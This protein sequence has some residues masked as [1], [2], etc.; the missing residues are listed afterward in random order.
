MEKINDNNYEL[1]LVRY[2]DDELTAGEREVVEEWLGE[3][4][5]AAEELALY[6]EAP[7]L[8]ADTTVRYDIAQ[9]RHSKPLWPVVLHWSAAA[10][11]VIAL[12]MPIALMTD[13]KPEGPSVQVAEA[14]LPEAEVVADTVTETVAPAVVNR[15][16]SVVAQEEALCEVLPTEPEVVQPQ[17]DTVK[18]VVPV[19]EPEVIFCDYLIVYEQDPDTTYTNNLVVYDNIRRSWMEELKERVAENRVVQWVHRRFKSRETYLLANITE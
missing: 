2:A 15:H 8:E 13:V 6:C 16:V 4:P 5:E 12:M 14:T 17:E 10:A 7:R 19:A 9:P 3:H 18:P 1:W 11:V